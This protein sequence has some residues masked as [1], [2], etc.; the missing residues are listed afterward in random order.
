S[1]RASGDSTRNASPRVRAFTKNN[2]Q[3]WSKATEN[4]KFWCSKMIFPLATI[5]DCPNTRKNK[6]DYAALNEYGLL[7]EDIPPPRPRK[8][9]AIRTTAKLPTPISTSPTAPSNV[10][11]S[12][13][14]LDTE[15]CPSQ[16]ISQ[17]ECKVE[18]AEIKQNDETRSKERGWV[19]KYYHTTPESGTWRFRNKERLEPKHLCIVSPS[20]CRFFRFA[21]K[22]RSSTTASWISEKKIPFQEEI[23]NWIVST[24]R[25]FTC[26]EQ[27]SFKAML[28]SAGFEYSIPGADTASRPF[29]LGLDSLGSELRILMA[30]ASSIALSLDG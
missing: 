15:I 26:V 28:K 1:N 17:A 20:T 7:T 3:T 9:T 6:R 14:N 21:S 23:P 11:R 27:P 13:S 4:H 5:F 30:S 24:C 29:C 16:S 18:T 22:L 12:L 8:K 10:S 19:W 25:P 2:I